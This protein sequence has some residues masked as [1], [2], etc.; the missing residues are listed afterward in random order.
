MT[1]ERG[2]VGSEIFWF[3]CTELSLFAGAGKKSLCST[4]A[5]YLFGGRSLCETHAIRAAMGVTPEMM[6]PNAH[7]TKDEGLTEGSLAKPAE[8]ESTSSAEP[9]PSLPTDPVR[10]DQLMKIDTSIARLQEKR[11][12]LLETP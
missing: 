10:L 8:T 11:Q 9:T 3:R 4:P 5:S 6:F 1:M 2:Y 12:R 7:Q